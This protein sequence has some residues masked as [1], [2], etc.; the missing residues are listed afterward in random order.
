MFTEQRQEKILQLLNER[1]SITVGE[2]TTI[3]DSSES[4]IR[5]DL[6]TLDKAGKL[7]KMFGGAVAKDAV[8]SMTE[9]SVSQ[10]EN[11]NSDEKQRIARYAAT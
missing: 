10:K 7:T 1:G 2:L 5:R 11:V 8:Y 9:L 4:T 3:L 6:N